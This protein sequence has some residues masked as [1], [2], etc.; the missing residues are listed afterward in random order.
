[1]AAVRESHR[2]MSGWR[3]YP[4]FI[5]ARWGF[6][7]GSRSA[8]RLPLLD[9]V[10]RKG[11]WLDSYR[12]LGSSEGSVQA[13]IFFGTHDENRVELTRGRDLNLTPLQAGDPL[14]YFIYPYAE[15]D[16]KPVE[17]VDRV[18]SWKDQN[19]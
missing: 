6:R 11:D 9:G 13:R 3:V 15:A 14:N 19:D 2:L 5:F 12:R 17:D 7:R 18:F 16:G 8:S 10:L 4:I 1:M